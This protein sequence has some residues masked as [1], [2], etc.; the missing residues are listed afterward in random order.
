[1]EVQ[2]KELIEKIKIDGV[3]DAELKA[4][5]IV[6]N[7]EAKADEI[8]AKAKKEASRII[9]GAKEE[10]VKSEQSGR[11]ALKQAGRDLVLNLQTKITDLFNIII[12]KE[13]ASA[14]DDKVLAET[15]VKLIGSWKSGTEN[16]Q[17]LLSEKDYRNVENV[18][19]T[20]LADQIKKGFE[21]KASKNLDA[22]F[23]VSVKDGSAYHNFSAE[24][25]SEVLS[26]YLNPRISS[27]LNEGV[28]GKAGA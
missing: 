27:L 7:A 10:A 8:V 23:L 22:G 4:A 15:I 14:M 26:E 11:E 9:A 24:G 6:K 18:L 19:R 12:K 1:M 5:D 17:V 25:I 16:L 20:K 13:V 2:L 21:V 28:K 3:K